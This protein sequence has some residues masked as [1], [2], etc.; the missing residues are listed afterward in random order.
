MFKRAGLRSVL[1][2][3]DVFTILLALFAASWLRPFLEFGKPLAAVD[4]WPEW[5]VF[6]IA[7][8]VWTLGFL[9]LDVYNLQKNLRI[10]DEVQRLV[11]SHSGSLPGKKPLTE[12]AAEATRE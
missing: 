6:S 5:P 9:L 12:F 2:L 3:G 4:V 11:F 7:L 1:L 10:I 8:V